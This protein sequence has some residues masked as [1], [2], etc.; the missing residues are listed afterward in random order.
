M[1]KVG[2]LRAEPRE[3]RL[4]YT[5]FNKKRRIVIMPTVAIK[6]PG[7]E[8]AGEI[9]L[10]E[11]VFGAKRN[12]PLIH[13]AVKV[14]LE[15]KRQ[16][17]K[18]AKGRGDMEWGGRKPYKQKGTGRAR[19][20]STTAPHYRHG[21]KALAFHPR[22]LGHAFPKKMRRGAI[23]SALSAKLADNE[24]VIVDALPLNGVIST[25]TAAAFLHAV[26]AGARKSLVVVEA[27]DPVMVKSVRN[28]AGVTVRFAPEFSTRDVVDGGVI[29]M[30]RA[31][32][33]KI[34]AL[35]GGGAKSEASEAAEEAGEIAESVVPAVP[36]TEPAEETHA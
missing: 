35:L 12:I 25:K 21:G 16:G 3:N 6:S 5:A 24:L 10:S 20:G 31:A 17:T 29:V 33:E 36:A 14:E 2:S 22:D 9:A 32:V 27:N 28:I 7:G 26:T 1:L 30:T 4:S 23:R 18:N 13:Q 19:Q 11:R 15:N 8:S 34:E